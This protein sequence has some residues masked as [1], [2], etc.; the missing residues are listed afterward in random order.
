M[1]LRP[2]HHQATIMKLAVLAAIHAVD[3]SP[4]VGSTGG[5]QHLFRQ[6]RR[7]GI[8]EIQAGTGLPF[9]LGECY[10]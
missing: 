9:A 5:P 6:V 2:S 3:V 4:V 7:C 8:G 1:Q 10:H